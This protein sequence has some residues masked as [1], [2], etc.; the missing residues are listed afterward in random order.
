MGVFSKTPPGLF[1]PQA[2]SIQWV[3]EGRKDSPQMPA[4][5]AISG[6]GLGRS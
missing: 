3:S 1:T 2:G 6:W 4:E 5:A